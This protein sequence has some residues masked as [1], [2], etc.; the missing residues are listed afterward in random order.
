MYL[1]NYLV[2]HTD[3]IMRLGDAWYLLLKRTA[4]TKR[5]E[6]ADIASNTERWCVQFYPHHFRV[7][8]HRSLDRR[9]IDTVRLNK[10]ETLISLAP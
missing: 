2:L 7:R 9:R 10:N 3:R 5:S 6:L 4:R 8:S 1:G